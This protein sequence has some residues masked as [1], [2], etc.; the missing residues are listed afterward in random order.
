MKY[1]IRNGKIYDGTGS[2]GYFGDILIENG[3]IRKI[4]KKERPEEKPEYDI[5]AQM[6]EAKGN[7]VTPGFIDT[8]RH[9]DLAALYD[10]N[11]GELEIAQ[12]L[13]SIMG[14]NCGLGIFPS[15]KEHGKEM[16]DFV[17]PCLGIG[18]RDYYFRLQSI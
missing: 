14:G 18:K 2:P 4:W 3:K 5:E 10:E 8:H 17:E 11:F 7:I 15:T 9:C 16:Y 6:I 13:T 12:G 1:V